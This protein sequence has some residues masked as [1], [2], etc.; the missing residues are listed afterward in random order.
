MAKKEFDVIVVGDGPVGLTFALLLAR[1]TPASI[2]LVGASCQEKKT[3]SQSM[4]VSSLNPN[5]IQLYKSLGLWNDLTKH[6]GCFKEIEVYARQQEP[7]LHFAAKQVQGD[8]LGSIV[9]HHH[10]MAA[11]TESLSQHPVTRI[12]GSVTAWDSASGKLTLSQGDILKAKLVVGAD[13]AQSTIR[14]QA[15]IDLQVQ[16]CKQSA[17]V[18]TLVLSNTHGNKCY[19]RFCDAGPIAL[20]PLKESRQVSCVWSLDQPE[21]KRVEQLSARA[22]VKELAQKINLP[23]LGA[24]DLLGDWHT[25]PLAQRHAKEYCKVGVALIGDAAHTV[26][27]LAGMGLNMGLLDAATLASSLQRHSVD[28]YGQLFVLKPYERSRRGDHVLVLQ[29]MHWLQEAFVPQQ[30]IFASLRDL[31]LRGIRGCSLGQRG[32]I[33]LASGALFRDVPALMQHDTCDAP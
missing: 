19:Q 10:L 5:S 15:G 16:D 9:A 17:M 21:Y 18:A 13:G 6:S 33:K 31:A 7:A 28:D 24:M 22:R 4:K 20:L 1:L 26:H 2:A 25:F 32:L 27:P 23:A 12:T 30:G 11:L 3:T 14:E 8:S 29:V